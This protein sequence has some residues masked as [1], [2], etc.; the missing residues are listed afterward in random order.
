MN[1]YQKKCL[2]KHGYTEIAIKE[3]DLHQKILLGKTR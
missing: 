3:I 1:E 2:K